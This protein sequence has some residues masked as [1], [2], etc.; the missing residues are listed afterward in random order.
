VSF[1]IGRKK[2]AKSKRAR[3]ARR[4]KQTVI[5]TAAEAQETT[6]PAPTP[7]AVQNDV[8]FAKEYFYV[9]KELRNILI[10]TLVMFAV[11][12]GLAYFI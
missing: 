12:A 8:N 3:R 2:M 6:Q 5:D 10:V 9:Y 11:M 7:P 1:Y 4:Q